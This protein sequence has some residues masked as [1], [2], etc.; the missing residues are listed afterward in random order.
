[1]IQKIGYALGAS[2]P[3]IILGAIDYDSKGETA[4]Q[5]LHVLTLCYSVIPGVLVLAAAWLTVRYSLTEA[6]HREIRKIIDAEVTTPET[7][8]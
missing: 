2:L 5:A 6:R 7:P 8:A 1:M 4:P 3:L